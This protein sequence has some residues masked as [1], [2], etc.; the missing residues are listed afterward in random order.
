MSNG[1]ARAIQDTSSREQGLGFDGSNPTA[2]SIGSPSQ[3]L[4]DLGTCLAIEFP[5]TTNDSVLR[6]L[7]N[8]QFHWYLSEPAVDRIIWAQAIKPSGFAREKRDVSGFLVHFNS[9]VSTREFAKGSSKNA[10]TENIGLM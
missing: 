3:F 5:G 6:H 9:I 2:C 8:L 1:R 4:I 7:G 10:E